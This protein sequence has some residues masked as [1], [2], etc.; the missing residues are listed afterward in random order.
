MAVLVNLRGWVFSRLLFF[1]YSESSI[2]LRLFVDNHARI[3]NF[4]LFYFYF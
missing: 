2:E 4:F 3:S 1:F